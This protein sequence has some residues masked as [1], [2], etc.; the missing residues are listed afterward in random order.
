MSDDGGRKC[1]NENRSVCIIDIC[2]YLV[3]TAYHL[4]MCTEDIHLDKDT[5]HYLHNFP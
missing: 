4:H 3:F 5:C 2:T 1:M